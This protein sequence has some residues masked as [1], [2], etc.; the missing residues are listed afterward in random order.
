M[1]VW[2]RHPVPS[3][4]SVGIVLHSNT[5]NIVDNPELP[6]ASPIV[7]IR[8]LSHDST[9]HNIRQDRARLNQGRAGVYIF[10]VSMASLAS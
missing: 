8:L 3:K 9:G 7:P 10:M 6:W 2:H 4:E 1:F 5:H